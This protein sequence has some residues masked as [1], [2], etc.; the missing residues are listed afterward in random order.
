MVMRSDLQVLREF[1]AMTKE[2]RGNRM[3][4]ILRMTG[5]VEWGT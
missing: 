5:K 2:E 3:L 1:P 4:R